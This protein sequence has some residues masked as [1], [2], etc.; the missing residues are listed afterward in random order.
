MCREYSDVE[1][2]QDGE[3]GGGG[4][5][6]DILKGKSRPILDGQSGI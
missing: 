6:R 3:W 1:N 5:F 2:A 4:P